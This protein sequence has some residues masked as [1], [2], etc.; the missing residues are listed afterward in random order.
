MLIKLQKPKKQIVQRCTAQVVRRIYILSWITSYNTNF[1][2]S[3]LIAGITLGLTMIPQ[4]I[5]YATLAGLSSEYGLY[6]AFIGSFTY[7]IFGS[8]KQVSIGP[9][10][11]MAL[12]VLPLTTGKPI[13]YVFVLAFIAGCIELLLGIFKM[14]F[15]VDLIPIPVTNAFTSAT[16]LVIIASQLKN[17]TGLKIMGTNFSTYIYGFFENITEIKLG[18]CVL[19]LCCCTALLLL[20]KLQDVPIS[21]GNP[22]KATIKKI[23]WYIT[24]S[25]N[26]LVVAVTSIVAYIWSN[27]GAESLPFKLSGKVKSG[28]PDFALPSFSIERNGTVTSFIDILSDFG[29]G[30]VFVPLVA[31]LAN[32]S[33]AKAFSTGKVVDASQEMIALGLCNILG[34]FVQSMPTCGAFTRSAVSEASG[35]KTPM[36]GI[37]SGTMTVLALT[38]LT[39]YFYFIPRATL[40]SVLICAVYF[41]IDQKLPPKLWKENRKD[42]YAWLSCFLVCIAFGVEIGLL[43]G[44][45]FNICMLILQWMRPRIKPTLETF[46]DMKYVKIS[47]TLGI[48]YPGVDYLR[49]FINKVGNEYSYVNYIVIDCSKIVSLDYTAIKGIENIVLDAKSRDQEIIFYNLPSNLH[50]QLGQVKK[51]SYY[52]SG[53]EELQRLLLSHKNDVARNCSVDISESSGNNNNHNN[54][55]AL[56]VVTKEVNKEK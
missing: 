45:F 35:V 53:S 50:A 42:F 6:A 32:V 36:A 43:F 22:H 2:F 31:I 27:G 19:G 15:I 9:T 16:S 52:C 39:P 1:F 41:M 5:A 18:D 47:P 17:V 34:S 54:G 8:V 46:E 21:N 12:L 24:I 7:V 56:A 55:T 4:A 33:I 38:F 44:I 3:D 51:N 29:I 20:R 13:E 40:G 37:Y 11:L 26:A 10:S 49:G 30:T 28:V 23:L 25:R 48:L 14:G